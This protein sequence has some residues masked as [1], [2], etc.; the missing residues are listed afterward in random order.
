MSILTI[1]AVE[2]SSGRGS[3]NVY[4]DA[5]G[6]PTFCTCPGFRLKKGHPEKR[7]PCKHMRLLGASSE[8]VAAAKQIARLGRSNSAAA[9]GA[10]AVAMAKVQPRAETRRFSFIEV[11]EVV[12]D[13][14]VTVVDLRRIAAIEME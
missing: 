5:D 9:R 2:S 7:P 14:R 6:G 8:V 3:Y 10:M 12:S 1:V 13:S 4:V 11:Q